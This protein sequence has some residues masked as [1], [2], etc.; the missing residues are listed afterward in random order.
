MRAGNHGRGWAEEQFHMLLPRLLHVHSGVVQEIRRIPASRRTTKLEVYRRLELALDFIRSNYQQPLRLAQIA[1]AACLSTHHFLRLFKSVYDMTPHQY[2]TQV[3]LERAHE[4]LVTTD[5]SITE[6]CFDVGFES[7][8]SF[9]TL[10][11]RN[12]GESPLQFRQ[13]SITKKQFSIGTTGG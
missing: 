11:R 7:P 2:L 6:I 9:S 8:T 12:F 10:F 13:R 1:R 5:R 3:R 4:L